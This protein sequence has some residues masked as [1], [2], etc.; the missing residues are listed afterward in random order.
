MASPVQSPA[1]N[2]AEVWENLEPQGWSNAIN[3]EGNIFSD[4]YIHTKDLIEKELEFK[5][6]D[7]IIEVIQH[8]LLFVSLLISLPILHAM[9]SENVLF[10]LYNYYIQVGCGSGEVISNITTSVPRVGVD[11]NESFITMCK[12]RF[13]D[14]DFHVVGK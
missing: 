13:V 3:S 1:S 10:T 5:K 8:C 4:L 9:Y 7:L 2:E 6:H 11:I 12:E 14:I